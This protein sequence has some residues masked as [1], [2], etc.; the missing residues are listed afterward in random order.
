MIFEVPA[1]GFNTGAAGLKE[2]SAE[3]RGVSPNKD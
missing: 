2:I 3:I 1:V